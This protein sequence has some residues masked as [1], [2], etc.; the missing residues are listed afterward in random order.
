M[1]LLA[2]YP[3]LSPKELSAVYIALSVQ[4]LQQP[5]EVGWAEKGRVTQGW[6]EKG[7]VTQGHST[8]S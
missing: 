1:H 3:G 5:H 8:A 2:F 4:S 7:R 6:A